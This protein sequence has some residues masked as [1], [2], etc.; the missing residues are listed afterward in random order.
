V[1]TRKGIAFKSNDFST[2]GIRVVRASDIK[3]N[4]IK[5][6]EVF[7]PEK[8]PAIYPKAV[9]RVGEIILSTVGSTP[10]VR[11]SAVGQMGI[12]PPELDGTLLNQN[13]VVLSLQNPQV[14]KKFFSYFLISQAY[15]KHLD[16]H[17]HGSANQASLNIADMLNFPIP[18][19][20][21]EEQRR[22]GDFLDKISIAFSDAINA[23]LQEME[24]ILEL[25]KIL[26]ANAVTGKVKI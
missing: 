4:T 20:A 9:L 10:D 26:I 3:N 13:T 24:I 7:L 16:L 19:P 8:F 6:S 1:K 12:V 5:A 11:E 18:Y 2:E 14:S 21:L 22:I 17:A 15:R 23:A 25:K